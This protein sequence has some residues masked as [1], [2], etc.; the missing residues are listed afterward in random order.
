MEHLFRVVANPGANVTRST[1]VRSLSELP[2][3][4]GMH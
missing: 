2:R 4:N 3:K 1:N